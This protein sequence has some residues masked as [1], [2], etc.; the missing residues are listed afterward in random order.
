MQIYQVIFSLLSTNILGVTL[1]SQVD[2]MYHD[3]SEVNYLSGF[4]NITMS[5]H[6]RNYNYKEKTVVRRP[7]L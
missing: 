3:N 6:Y 1:L 2:V 7:Y 4:F 5:Y